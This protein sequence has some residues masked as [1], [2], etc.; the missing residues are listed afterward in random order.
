MIRPVAPR[1]AATVMLLRDAPEL[2]VLLLRRSRNTP[3]VPGAHVFPGGAVDPR[4]SEPRLAPV[5]DGLD[6]PS[7]SSMLGVETDATALW[8]AAVRECLE[9]AGV[10]LARDGAGPMGADHAVLRD[11]P[12]LRRRVESGDEHLADLYARHGLRIPLDDLVYVARWITP[13]ESP[14]RY[15]TRFFAAAMPAGQVA[16]V[17]RWEAVHASWW[18]PAEALE[19][20]Q[21]GAIDLIEPTVA[22][23]ALLAEFPSTDVALDT[24]RAGARRTERVHEPAGGVRVP[25]PTELSGDDR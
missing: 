13:E 23:L 11:L 15:D 7:A 1:R 9:E 25:L 8:V 24:L 5:V 16:V 19:S 18:Q 6:E 12:E 17:D 20:W 4:D 22:S 3:F 21:A 2:E 10:L 14:R